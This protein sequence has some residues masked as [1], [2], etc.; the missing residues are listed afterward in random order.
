MK[1]IFGYLMSMVVFIMSFM[2]NISI[3]AFADEPHQFSFNIYDWDPTANDWYGDGTE[4]EYTNNS[5]IEPG[6]VFQVDIYYKPGTT[7]A[8][9][10]TP[11]ITYDSSLIEPV[12]DTFGGPSDEIY[13]ERSTQTTADGGIWP[14]SGTQNK[15]PSCRRQCEKIS[16][17]DWTVQ[18]SKSSKYD[19]IVFLITDPD[20][21]HPITEEGVLATVYFKV[22]EDAPAGSVINLDFYSTESAGRTFTAAADSTAKKQPVA[23]S[24]MNIN[25]YG[26]MSNNNT[27]KT[28]TVSNQTTVYPL[29]GFVSGSKDVKEYTTVVPN[30]ITNVDIAATTTDETSTIE[31]GLGNQLLNIGENSF[32]IT[33]LAQNGQ[34]EIYT[35]KVYRLSNDASLNTL[36]LS[37]GVDIGSFSS[38][39]LNYTAL[40][41]Y[42]TSQT[43]ISATKNHENAKIVS[44]T[45]SWN[46]QNYGA[47]INTK[48]IVVQAENCLEKYNSVTGNTC[49]ENKYKIDIT[50]TAPST[51]AYLST[52]TVDSNNIL[53]NKDTT[54]YNLPNVQNNVTKINIGATVEDTGK[55]NI[56]TTLGNKNLSVGDNTIEV[57]VTAE[58]GI[59]TK[60]YTI[61]VRR[62]SNDSKLSSLT[63][64]SDPVGTFSPTFSSTFL[65]YYTYTAAPTVSKVNI[66]A[67]VNDKGNAQIISGTGEFDID[68]NP[69]INVT[70][71]AEDGSQ[72]IYVVKLVRRKS[73]NAYL[74]S[75]SIDGYNLNKAFNKEDTLYTANVAGSVTS[76]NISAEVEDTGKATIV[77]GTGPQPLNV[78]S[79]TIQV[80]V[81]AEDNSTKD[82]T[83]TITRAP[84]QV[85]ALTDLTVD[86][87]TVPEFNEKT[88]EYNLDNVPFSK[89]SITIGATKKDEDSTVTGTGNINLNTGNNK[90]Y[91]AVTAQ[92][93]TTTTT[94][95]INVYREKDSNNLLSDLRIDNRTIAGF[96]KND[97]DYEITVP[98][99]TKSLNLVATAESNSASVI[100]SGNNNFVTTNVNE[101]TITVT[102]ENG[103]INTYVISVTREKS[104]NNYLK[105]ITLSDGLLNPVF[106]KTTQE[107]KVNVG[108]NVTAITI[109]PEV[110][111]S[112][113]TASISGPSS[114]II[115]DNIYEITV[116][117]EKG[118]NDRVYRITVTRNPS[119]NNYLSDLTIDANTLSD[120]SKTKEFYS[121]SVPQTKNSITIGAQAEES[122]SSIIIRKQGDT[123]TTETTSNTFNLVSGVNSFEVIVTAENNETRTYS[124]VVTKEKSNDSTLSDLSIT[125]TNISPT[126]N[127]NVKNYTASVA[128][129]VTSIDIVATKNSPD[130]TVTGDG[131]KTLNTGENTFNIVVTAEDNTTTTYT[132]VVTRA[133]NDNSYL[134]NLVVSGGFTLKPN[135]DREETKYKLNV[136]NA[137]ES[138]SITA[139]KE[140][141]NSSVTG[142]GVRNLVT[143]TNNIDI[144]VT[145]EDGI[146]KKI[147][148]IEITR[149][150]SNDTTLKSL[151]ISSG[152]LNPS[153]NKETK[154]YEVVV[155]N[156]IKTVTINATP[157]S[158]KAQILITGIDT[159]EVGTN[160]ATITVTAEDGTIDYYT[161][162]ILRQP[163]SNNFLKTL[164]VKDKNNVEYIERFINTNTEY[165]IT[166]ENDIDSII[167][168][169]EKD[170]ETSTQVGGNGEETLDIGLNS[171]EISVTSAA[172]IERIYT[173]NVTRKANS[174][175]FLKDL[176]IVGQTL[177]PEFNKNVISYTTTVPS[178]VN[179]ITVNAHAEVDTSTVTGIGEHT[180]VTGV[181]NINIDVTSEDET[182]KTYVVVV[183]KE[184]SN[185]NYLSNL[186]ITPG[187]LTPVFNK[188]ENK[189]SVHVDNA[190]TMLTISAEKEHEAAS[191]TGA[192]IKSL[193]VGTQKFEITVKAENNEPRVYEITVTRD[194][195]SNK[196]LSDLTID[197]QTVQGFNKDV[198]EY[199]LNVDNNVSSIEVGALKVDD[200]ATVT[201]TGIKNLNTGEN[202]ISVT[203]TAED[204]TFK[205]YDLKVTRAKSTNNY[206][207]DLVIA[208]GTLSPEFNKEIT[209]YNITVPYE[210][211]N[212]TINAQTESDAA[213][214]EIDSNNNFIVGT[215]KVM[216]NVVSEDGTVRPYEI[217][218]TRQQQVNNFLTNMII[219]GNDNIRY[220]TNP[221]FDKLTLSYNV[222]LP[223][224]VTSVN[225]NV[226]KE[227]SSL[228][229][230]GDGNV[231]IT[232]LP[233]THKVIV[234][235]TG[236][237][238]RTYTITFKKGLS[239]NTNLKNITLSEG[240][241]SPAFN[242]DE[243]LYLV[244]LPS[245][246][247][248]ITVNA[249]KSEPEQI[250]TGDGEINLNPGDNRINLTV[251]SEN[252][253]TKFYKIIVVVGEDEEKDNVLNSITVNKGTLSPSFAE[254]IKYYQVDLDESEEDITIDAS[255]NNTVTGTGTYVLKMGANI[256][257]I[258]SIDQD[259]IENI[260]TVVV[261]RG[262]INSKY[263]ELLKIENHKLDKEFNKED[264]N[265]KLS[266][267]SIVDKLDVVAIPENKNASVEIT[268]NTNLNIGNN[269]ISVKVID[270]I[271]GELTYTV[272]V[273]VGQNKI[274]S[275]THIVGEK[276]ITTI[277]ENKTI[278]EVKNEMTNPKEY[279][280]IYDLDGN[281]VSDS[282]K[283][284]SGYTIKL[285][286]QGTVYDSKILIIKGDI[287]S[288]GEVEVG[289]LIM[290]KRSIL[291]TL[292]LNELQ[293]LAAD[294]N[295]DGEKEVA[296]L[297]MIKRHILQN[298][299]IFEKESE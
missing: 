81:K 139:Y 2:S 119:D 204:G 106:V 62:L 147:Y 206:L 281:E 121:I 144:T 28:L 68:D 262:N 65:N 124:I 251:T 86:N 56:T 284:A 47:T 189:Y 131:T 219:E 198:L 237:L 253:N 287:N 43:T 295:D 80:R 72:S 248:K 7:K 266:L 135:F 202:I 234:R 36:S 6:K 79:N 181:N 296:D 161:V 225:I 172:N 276:Y 184:A 16:V 148:T 76:V 203:V 12:Y 245:G 34:T 37:N 152:N 13:I 227:A 63:V 141:P 153:F 127:A 29:D 17:T 231:D 294:V 123:S 41:P 102:A 224:T 130:A 168:S 228:T 151:T 239:S 38:S 74:K 117:N 77:Y 230:E 259:G 247:K 158:N 128:H 270:P 278:E 122:Y 19:D 285:Q 297:I 18:V 275:N 60:T 105:S 35:V 50:R 142:D 149:A 187:T 280:K 94:Y 179:K 26:E 58:D 268:G 15:D 111:D 3:N 57:V 220:S 150:K 244:N 1:K 42:S 99:E 208:E 183:T 115:G 69:S 162:R 49:S 235:T 240:T 249:E 20:N 252:G 226:T 258:K 267:K 186:S 209:A 22:K 133:K 250:V 180:L 25:V 299:N 143:G 126:F 89:T 138:V 54:V 236:G 113:A 257:E 24:G 159:L 145:A 170:D 103:T 66:Q 73:N 97:N 292:N 30:Q 46:L 207:S 242:E 21:N 254:D 243:E 61:N 279:L 96:N 132:V 193:S 85:A 195:S 146:T 84:K 53:T 100:V 210:V 136:P 298:M 218:V 112:S 241:L 255:S 88:L 27:L 93:K 82:Y 157:N 273:E 216:V 177:S 286:I 200:T 108:R 71:Q 290:L 163:S 23:T 134:S 271:E 5:D 264:L 215:N 75:L 98:N 101:V 199:T 191:I 197:G 175:A 118:V 59:T 192:G 129:T 91:V 176:E 140:D 229:V 78:G 154:E 178:T 211:T 283:A 107:Y 272:N 120:F 87:V 217:T 4:R 51:N 83:I 67:T 233:Q 116:A 291:E 185:N 110:E 194:A 213:K 265:Y 11:V 222:E 125:Q 182:V 196:D 70:V 205:V 174:N 137:T 212:L 171:F 52:L 45:G 167:I 263:L 232:S 190:T 90:L 9:G 274:T 40:V 48:E 39:T 165:N 166:V 214:V 221:A 223:K 44:G 260:Y 188:E 8:V 288:N 169:S 256:F 104:E 164:S 282:S 109:T 156:E 95:I 293:L 55:A 173:I 32:D 238:E 64:T 10:L 246:T 92:D 160:T 261:N 201:G 269:I 114:L 14:V 33:V 155:Q 289:D 277:R 31:T